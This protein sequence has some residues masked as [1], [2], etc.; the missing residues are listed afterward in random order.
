MGR[1]RRR[2]GEGTNNASTFFRACLNS[3]FD[4]FTHTNTDDSDV[5]L[6]SASGDEPNGVGPVNTLITSH[7]PIVHF[8]GSVHEPV[9]PREY[10][11]TSK[12][13]VKKYVIRLRVCLC[14]LFPRLHCV[15]P[16]L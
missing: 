8:E 12:E 16:A 9:T 14:S 5:D 1:G 13:S 6:L 15:P 11:F 4:H 2:G 10:D 3:N 7:Q